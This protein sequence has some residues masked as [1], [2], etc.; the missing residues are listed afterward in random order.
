MQIIE[1]SDGPMTSDKQ[2]QSHKESR[3]TVVCFFFFGVLSLIYDEISVIAAE[4]VLAGSTVATST[5]VLSI[6]LPVLLIKLTAPWVVQGVS[7][8]K[9]VLLIILLFISGLIILVF[10]PHISGRLLGVSVTEAGVSLSE[11]TFL[12]LTAF[13]EHVTVSAFVAG[14]GTSSLVGPLYYTGEHWCSYSDPHSTPRCYG[15][16][17]CISRKVTHLVLS[18]RLNDLVL[19]L[20]KDHH[21][22]NYPMALTCATSVCSP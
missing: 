16:R 21:D 13:Y 5:V 1:T 17:K 2:I 7:H 15:L 6:A 22:V 11:I 9:K 19:R 14:I 8:I 3:R 12:S 4:D 18:F 20:S 10:T